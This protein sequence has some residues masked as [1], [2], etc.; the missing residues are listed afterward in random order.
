MCKYSV[1][2]TDTRHGQPNYSWLRTACID[3][4]CDATSKMLVRR[5]KRAL[6]ISAPHALL[7]DSGDLIRINLRRHP[8]TILIS[9]L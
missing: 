8:I 9:V 5:A 3:A 1:E 2:M 6:G 7:S 4:P